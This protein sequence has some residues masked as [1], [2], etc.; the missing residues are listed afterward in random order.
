MKV[1]AIILDNKIFLPCKCTYEEGATLYGSA[2]YEIEGYV[3]PDLT[4]FT[5]HIFQFGEYEPH[6]IYDIIEL[7]EYS[8]YRNFQF[9]D[10]DL[11]KL[12]IPYKYYSK[13]PQ[14]QPI[15]NS[16]KGE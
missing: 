4:Y 1:Q 5:K 3:T 7:N 8:P 10:I 15:I 6:D 14:L 12:E 13:L 11:Q 2:S 16:I 9:E